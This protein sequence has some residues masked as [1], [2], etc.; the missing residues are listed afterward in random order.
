MQV[1]DT[2]KDGTLP[3]DDSWIFVFGSNLRGVHGAGAAWI[4]KEKFGAQT[5]VSLGMTGKSFAIPTKDR[6]MKP[7]PIEAIAEYVDFFVDFTHDRADLKFWV[8]R[9]GCGLAGYK[10]ELIA[11]LFRWCNSNCSFAEEWKEYLE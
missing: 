1:I 6:Y 8:T 10:D 5:G 7:L 2:H 4:A 11:P 3:P 9:V